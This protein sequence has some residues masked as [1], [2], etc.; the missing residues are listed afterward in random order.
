[1]WNHAIQFEKVTVLVVF[2][3]NLLPAA[4]YLNQKCFVNKKSER[5]SQLRN[6]NDTTGLYSDV[7]GNR[8]FKA[9]FTL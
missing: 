9:Q 3:R 5:Q 6:K 8:N 4:D 2:Q 1:M 7:V